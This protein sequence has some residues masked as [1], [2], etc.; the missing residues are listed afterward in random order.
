MTTRARKNCRDRQL[1]LRFTTRGGPREGAGRKKGEGVSHERRPTITRHSGLLLTWKILPGLPSLRHGEGRG[2][3]MGVM[4]AGCDRHG[5]RVVQFSIQKDH[6]HL[7][8]EAEDNHSLAEGAKALAVRLARALNRLWNRKGTV[9]SERYHLR[10]FKSLL[11]VRNVLLY[12]LKNARRHRVPHPGVHDP[13]SSASWF[14]QWKEEIEVDPVH[15]LWRPVA[16]ARSWIL[17]QGWWE[18]HGPLGIRELPA[19]ARP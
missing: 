12:V 8:A 15:F 6:L 4:A 19:A 9:F 14:E 3:L 11:A 16:R 2:L 13:F 18:K 17:R 5:F 10:V 7:V 1:T